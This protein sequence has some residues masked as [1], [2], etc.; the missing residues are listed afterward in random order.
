M[1]AREGNSTKLKNKIP[2]VKKSKTNERRRRTNGLK[3]RKEESE[4]EIER[5]NKKNPFLGRRW[6][7]RFAVLQYRKY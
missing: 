5:E 3:E 2:S 1:L 7:P 4:R 6:Q